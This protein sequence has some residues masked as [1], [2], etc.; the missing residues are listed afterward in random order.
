MMVSLVFTTFIL[1]DSNGDEFLLLGARCLL[2]EAGSSA[3]PS[4]VRFSCSKV[5]P[6]LIY[7]YGNSKAWLFSLKE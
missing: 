6:S 4:P 5:T 2:H 1:F 7:N 3:L